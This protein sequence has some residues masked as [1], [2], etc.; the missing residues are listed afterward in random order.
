[1]REHAQPAVCAGWR[2][3]WRTNAVSLTFLHHSVWLLLS[4]CLCLDS[5]S[6]LKK[7]PQGQ[8]INRKAEPNFRK[9][10][11]DLFVSQLVAVQDFLK[12]KGGG[13]LG[14]L[15]HPTVLN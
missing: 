1:M 9:S 7:K 3:A 6:V 2:G 14:V 15:H 5:A 12:V 10:S 13:T 8:E 11:Q 4:F